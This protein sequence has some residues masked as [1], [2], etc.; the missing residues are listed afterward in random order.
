MRRRVKDNGGAWACVWRRVVT[1]FEESSIGGER[2]PQRSWWSVHALELG[3]SENLVG[4]KFLMAGCLDDG[5]G[6]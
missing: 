4:K 2:R 3:S 5:C 1:F 6:S